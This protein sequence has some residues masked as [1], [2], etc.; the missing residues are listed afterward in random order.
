MTCKPI[1][2]SG[3]QRTWEN[4]GVYVPELQK[5]VTPLSDD[6][7]ERFQTDS[8]KLEV[9]FREGLKE[10]NAKVLQYTEG[11]H[12]K[13]N[14]N[15][16]EYC[17]MLCPLAD[18][19]KE[20]AKGFQ[21]KVTPLAEELQEKMSTNIEDFNTNVSPYAKSVHEMVNQQL[22]TLQQNSL[23]LYKVFGD[24]TGDKGEAV[25]I[26][27]LDFQKAFAC[28]PYL[29]EELSS[30]VYAEIHDKLVAIHDNIKQHQCRNETQHHHRQ[31]P[32]RRQHREI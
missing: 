8:T 32:N 22:E 18:D 21:Q 27:H 15:V 23:D 26:L 28:V 19:L 29:Y 10:F 25:H 1:G 4:L 20:N 7:H 31:P 14:H 9:K 5:I 12:N 24:V 11:L 2:A 3:F 16:E 17:I 30:K 6:I 13:V